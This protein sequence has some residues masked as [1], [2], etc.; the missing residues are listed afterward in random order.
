[1]QTALLAELKRLNGGKDIVFSDNHYPTNTLP[2][3]FDEWYAQV[4]AK[5]PALQY[6]NGQIEINRQQVKLNRALGLPK[7]SAGYMSEKLTKE[8]FQGVIVSMSIPLWENKNNVKQ[9]KAQ[10]TATEIALEDNKIQFYS[11][12]Q[13][14]YLKA[15]TLQQNAQKVRQ[16]LSLYGNEP[17]LKK[18]FDA[19]EI[20]LL[21]YLQEIEYYYEAVNR[22]LEAE[23][24]FELTVAEL[25]AM[26]M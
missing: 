8:H 12:L 1:E 9:A 26:E 2:S 6:L 16:S 13:N 10:V 23:R 5:S 14:L 15:I 19:G 3:N 4:E 17:L 18:A 21:N 11:R 22:A 25:S 24:N 7:F 20:S